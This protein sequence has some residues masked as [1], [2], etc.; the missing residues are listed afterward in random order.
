MAH[1]EGHEKATNHVD[2][3]TLSDKHF[4]AVI[5]RKNDTIAFTDERRGRV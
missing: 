4:P 2:K 1:A 5:V 3:N